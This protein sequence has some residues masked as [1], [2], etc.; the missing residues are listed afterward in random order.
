[1]KSGSFAYSMLFLAY[2]FCAAAGAQEQLRAI[3]LKEENGFLHLEISQLS[4]RSTGADSIE[5][6]GEGKLDT[7][8]QRVRIEVQPNSF[9]PRA[10]VTHTEKSCTVTF[11]EKLFR[12]LAER[13]HIALPATSIRLSPHS[14]DAVV[15]EGTVESVETKPLKLLLIDLISEE[16]YSEWYLTINIQRKK[17]VFA[18]KNN[19]YREPFV[20]TFLR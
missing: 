10:G 17:I 15:E 2:W 1:M 4:V 20:T 5:I 14:F 7:A 19:Q 13:L 9:P 16:L 12:R 6:V 18:E 8:A 3:E 11:D